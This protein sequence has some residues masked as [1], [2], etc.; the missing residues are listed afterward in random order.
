VNGGGYTSAAGTVIGGQTVD[1]QL[2]AAATYS[3]LVS[4]TLTIGG[5]A[6]TFDVTSGVAPAD[7]T[8]D[9]F[10]FT[11]QTGLPVSTQVVS[12]SVTVSGISASAPIASS[13]GEYSIDNGGFTA[14]PGTIVNG[15]T[16]RARLTTSANVATSQTASVTIGGIVG[17]FTASTIGA[18]TTPD[19]FSFTAQTGA[20]RST[21]VTSNSV[22]VSG[23]SAAAAVAIVGGQYRVNGGGY[24]SA[25]G[26]VTNGQTV[27]VQLTSSPAYS[28]LTTATLTIGGVSGAFGVTTAALA[29]DTT[30]DAFSFASQTGTQRSTLATSST[31]VVSG[32]N[33]AAG[34]SIT[35][36]QYRIDSGA[37]TSAAGTVTAGQVISVQLTSS[38]A[39]STATVAT[40]TIGG[41]NGQFSATTEA[42]DTTPDPFIFITRVD[43]RLNDNRRS[44]PGT[45]ILGINSPA[46][47]TVSGDPTSMYNINGGEFTSSPGTVNSGDVV[48]AHH[49]SSA[50]PNGEVTTT[51]TIGGVNGTFTTRSA[52]F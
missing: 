3:T 52:S 40:L 23:I 20:A 15:Q 19:A 1:V 27:E 50:T 31:M 30:P 16:V 35:G 8:P 10:A 41:V 25:A 29:V 38:A 32:I 49:R 12:D 42:A 48:R 28:T 39:F 37:Y 46:V 51:I 45:Q 44:Q 2:T 9:A 7:T 11:T 47:I 36:G 18:D 17:T 14:T 22:T 13:N 33:T 6:G 26:T 43:V 34:I 21:L 4:A 5:V 24:T